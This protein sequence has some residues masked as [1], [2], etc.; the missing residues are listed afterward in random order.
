VWPSDK[1]RITRYA[2]TAAPFPMLSD[3]DKGIYKVY[4]VTDSGF[5]GAARTLLHPRKIFN[6]IKT[7]QKNMEVDADPKLMPASFLIDPDGIIQ[8]A[9]YGRH[10]GDHPGIESIF[11]LVNKTV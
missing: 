7:M 6:A 4:G 10:F 5:L 11:Q 9:Y 2:G 3:K 1:D 8:L